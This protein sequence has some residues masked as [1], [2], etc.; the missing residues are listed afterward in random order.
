M[1]LNAYHS[2][3]IFNVPMFII[4]LV[5]RFLSSFFCLFPFT[6]FRLLFNRPEAH[7]GSRSV[8]PFQGH[9][10]NLSCAILR[11]SIAVNQWKQASNIILDKTFSF[12]PLVK[13][14]TVRLL[15]IRIPVSIMQSYTNFFLLRSASHVI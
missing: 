2:G 9:V 13:K 8:L 10:K 14:C 5:V 3:R 15:E 4:F 6:Y 1:G 11:R 7:H 12:L